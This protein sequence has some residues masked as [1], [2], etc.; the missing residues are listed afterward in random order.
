MKLILQRLKE[1]KAVR[2]LVGRVEPST[3]GQIDLINDEGEIMFRGFTCENGGESSDESGKD[4]RIIAREYSLEWTKT[5]RNSNS[6]LGEFKNVALWLK[7]KDLPS[8]ANRRILIHIGNFPS[9]TLGCILV[10]ESMSNKGYINSS[11]NAIKRLF[12]KLKDYDVSKIP[13]IV[14]EIE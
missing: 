14:K 3:L 4:K 7:T 6:K 13:L 9:D 5:Q 2:D 1:F 8:F 12:Y 10:G 11:V